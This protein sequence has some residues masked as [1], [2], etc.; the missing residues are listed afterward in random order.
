MTTTTV[1][2]EPFLFPNFLRVREWEGYTYPVGLLSQE[3]AAAYWDELKPLWLEH[4]ARKSAASKT[5]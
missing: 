2:I 4:V 1:H 5:P 3:Q